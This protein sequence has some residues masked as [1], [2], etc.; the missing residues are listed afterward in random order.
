MWFHI[1][2]IWVHTKMSLNLED[3]LYCTGISSCLGYW[4]TYEFWYATL[5]IH[6]H[7]S[8]AVRCMLIIMFIV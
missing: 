2:S 5:D 6:A 1:F 4:Y 8:V 7:V 3:N